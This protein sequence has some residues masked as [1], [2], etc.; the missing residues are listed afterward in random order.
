[1][2]LGTIKIT[3]LIVTQF[4]NKEFLLTFDE[5]EGRHFEC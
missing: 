5:Y 2:I 3:T 4:Y 1:M